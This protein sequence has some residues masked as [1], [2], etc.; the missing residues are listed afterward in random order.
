M[1]LLAV[2]SAWKDEMNRLDYLSST[3]DQM[4]AD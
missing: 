1:R 3:K 2:H 4:D